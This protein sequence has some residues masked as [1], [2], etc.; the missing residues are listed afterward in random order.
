MRRYQPPTGAAGLALLVATNMVLATIVLACPI[1]IR[2]PLVISWLLIVPGWAWVR[3]LRIRDRGD[4]ITVG[5]AISISLLAIISGGMAL[6]AAWVP[7]NVLFILIGVAAAGV[8]MPP[9]PLLNWRPR[10]RRPASHSWAG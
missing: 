8:L 9:L 5:I 2:M 6:A 3:R 4:Q 7:M 1:W 10:A